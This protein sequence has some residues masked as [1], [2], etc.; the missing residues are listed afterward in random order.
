MKRGFQRRYFVDYLFSAGGLFLLILFT[1][2][3]FYLKELPLPLSYDESYYWDWSRHL[4]WGYYS[5]PPMVAWLIFLSTQALGVSE[6]AVRL[7]A[8]LTSTGSLVLL[9][10]LTFRYLGE[11]SARFTLFLLG[12]VPIFFI[13]NFIMTIDPPLIFFLSLFFYGWVEYLLKPT[14]FRALLTGLALGLSL[15]TK[16]TALAFAGLS[17]LFLLLFDREKLYLKRTYLIYLV[18]LFL[19]A[20]NLYWNF[21]EGFWLLKHTEAEFKRRIGDLSYYVQFFGGLLFLYGPL[22]VPLLFYFGL[23][24]TRRIRGYLKEGYRNLPAETQKALLLVLSSF[25]FSFPPLF[26]LLAISFFIPL[27]HNWLMPFFLF[28]YLWVSYIALQKRSFRIILSLNLLIT[29]CL[30]LVVLALPRGKSELFT[31][32]R[33]RILYKFLGWRELSQMVERH[34]R[35]DLPLLV[36]HREVA[37][38]LAFYM[39]FH[40]EPYVLNLENVPGNQY[41][42]WRRD[43]EL[44]G[45]EVLFVQKGLFRPDVLGDAKRLDEIRLS[46]GKKEKSYSLWQGVFFKKRAHLQER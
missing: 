17:L 15:L 29:A 38:S 3:F 24:L 5:K 41:H 11:V 39:K 43:D 32:L 16:Q 14:F 10:V 20:P 19:Y 23:R 8:L 35:E 46:L 45:K 22:F 37:S 9:F 26:V 28:G 6:F 1:G 33:P 34:Y 27:N 44:I 21:K 30:S 40:P 4:D 13:Y 31:E 42:L 2:K 12:F 25:F 18:A 36:T 7:P